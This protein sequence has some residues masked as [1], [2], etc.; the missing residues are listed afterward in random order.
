MSRRVRRA[1]GLDP[2]TAERVD[3]VLRA[4]RR[5]GV[6]DRS[7]ARRGARAKPRPAAARHAAEPPPVRES[8]ACTTSPGRR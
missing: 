2:E 3:I 4:M 6:I 5:D 7:D 1:G 8:D